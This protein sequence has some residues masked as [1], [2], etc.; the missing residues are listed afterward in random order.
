VIAAATGA[1]VAVAVASIDGVRRRAADERTA[2]RWPD[3]LAAVRADL[4]AGM[5]LAAATVNAGRRVGGR[6]AT[7]AEELAEHHAAGGSFAVSL[8]EAR[9]RWRDPLADR[10]FTTLA[11]AAVTGGHRVAE[12]LAALS[13]SVADELRLRRAHHAATTQQRLTAAVALA[14]PWIL[15]VLTTA[16]NPQAAD[17]LTTPIGRLIVIGGFAATGLGYVLARRA[18]RLSRPPRVF[19]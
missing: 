11:A 16:T 1:I 19:R 14:A 4:A 5:P 15:L 8:R 3:F 17:A 6:F 7:L 13:E 9:D 2:D 18:A 10:I 12:I